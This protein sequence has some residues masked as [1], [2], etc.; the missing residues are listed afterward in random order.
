[1]LI[2]DGKIVDIGEPSKIAS[3]Y[4]KLNQKAIDKETEK[5]NKLLKSN[6][7]LIAKITNGKGE[8]QTSFKH[9]DKL[10]V[11][12]SWPNSLKIQNLGV[13]IIKE[14]GEYIFGRN[15]FKSKGLGIGDKTSFN[16][17]VELNFGYGRYYISYAG[18]GETES[19]V[20]EFISKGSSFIVKGE[21]ETDWEGLTYTDSKWYN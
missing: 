13:A 1:M 12:L 14:S 7:N 8:S 16:Y 19:E 15:T 5:N 6:S 21:V 17:E 20:V 3:M 11:H 4:S 18:F 2:D 10:L 9:G